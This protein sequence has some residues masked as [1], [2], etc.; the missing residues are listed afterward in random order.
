MGAVIGKR[1]LSVVF[2]ALLASIA[3]ACRAPDDD[4]AWGLNETRRVFSKSTELPRADPKNGSFAVFVPLGLERHRLTLAAQD[5]LRI[6]QDATIIRATLSSA[7]VTYGT[8]STMGEGTVEKNATL[9]ALYAYGRSSPRVETGATVHGYVRSAV[10]ATEVGTATVGIALLERMSSPIEGFTWRVDFHSKNRGAH[11][12]DP[13]DGKLSP[14]EPGA[15]SQ[16]L[17]RTGSVAVLRNGTYYFDDFKVEQGGTLEINNTNGAV[18]VWVR[19]SFELLG[20]MQEYRLNGDVLFG[21]AGS[22]PVIASAF[23]GTF[24][25]P[26]A[27]VRLPKAGGPHHGAF[28]AREIV[29]EPGVTVEHRS[30]MTW[31]N[32]PPVIS[33]ACN[34][35]A[36][37]ARRHVRDCCSALN[38]AR[39]LFAEAEERCAAACLRQGSQDLPALSGHC[40]A[41]CGAWADE[42]VIGE[43]AEF[44]RCSEEADSIYADCQMADYYRPDTCRNLGYPDY[45]RE[46]C[47]E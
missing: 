41:K 46:A 4:R 7:R 47:S 13:S 42:K 8:V 17:V 32:D 29:V 12:A 27:S 18:Y 9:G 33:L 38:R 20:P 30:F 6:G 3:A 28:F 36:I 24:V 40:A 23:R 22:K 11:L 21:F 10:P 25:A 19:N 43:E 44:E 37:Y 39:A 16:L 14:L 31:I 45:G 2:A 1:V 15:Y 35:C 26:A 5:Q 34:R